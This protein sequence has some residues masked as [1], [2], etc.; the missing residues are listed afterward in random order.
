MVTCPAP[1]S[2]PCDVSSNVRSQIIPLDDII[3]HRESPHLRSHEHP[4]LPYLISVQA[5][6]LS[7]PPCSLVVVLSA[8]IIIKD[9]L[10]ALGLRPDRFAIRIKFGISHCLRCRIINISKRRAR[11]VSLV[12]LRADCTRM[13]LH[14]HASG[15]VDLEV[16]VSE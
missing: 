15:H 4:C 6:A 2:P 10:S 14:V 9:L 5:K 13:V 16:R 12:A 3:V 1:E 7:K 11:L 8:A